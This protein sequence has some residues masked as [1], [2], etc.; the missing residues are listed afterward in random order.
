MTRE[1]P[2]EIFDKE[3]DDYVIVELQ[4]GNLITKLTKFLTGWWNT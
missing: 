1:T 4:E 3:E 2:P